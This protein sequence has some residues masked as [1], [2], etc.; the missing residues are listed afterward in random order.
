MIG[1]SQWLTSCC[2]PSVDI[3]VSVQ[4]LVSRS[5]WN[6]RPIILGCIFTCFQTRGTKVS[7]RVLLVFCMWSFYCLPVFDKVYLLNSFVNSFSEKCIA[8][9]CY[10]YRFSRQREDIKFGSFCVFLQIAPNC[11]HLS[12]DNCIYLYCDSIL[13]MLETQDDHYFLK[14]N[15]CYKIG[16][17]SSYNHACYNHLN[18]R[19]NI[20][21]S[22]KVAIE[23][24]TLIAC[25]VCKWLD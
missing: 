10:C 8:I 16:V 25:S 4:W 21:F 6:F 1:L 7:T 15:I 3:I 18:M 24:R 2:L 14:C 13:Y 22:N 20:S 9:I 23:E 5:F 17:C 12:N 19:W 11:K